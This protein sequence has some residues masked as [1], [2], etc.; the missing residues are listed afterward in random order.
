MS[1]QLTTAAELKEIAA[2]KL[3]TVITLPELGV[4]VRV[5]RLQYSSFI[6]TGRLPDSF[7]NGFTQREDGEGSAKITNEQFAELMEFR[8]QVVLDYVDSLKVVRENPGEDEVALSD[9]PDADKEAIL[10]AAQSGSIELKGGDSVSHDELAFFRQE[11]RVPSGS[12][13]G[14]QTES[15]AEPVDADSGGQSGGA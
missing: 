1:E 4:S 6:K 15:Q 5:R 9:F 3:S 12:D 10:T 11:Q 2:R 7:I 14:G 8:D 13:S